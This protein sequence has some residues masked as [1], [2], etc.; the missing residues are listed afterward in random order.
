MLRQREGSQIDR[1]YRLTLLVGHESISRETRT[2]LG[3]AARNQGQTSGEKGASIDHK[4]VIV[5]QGE[6]PS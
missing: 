1:G 3:A 5:M 4:E 2:A 6:T